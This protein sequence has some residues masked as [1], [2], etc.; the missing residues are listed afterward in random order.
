MEVGDRVKVIAKCSVQLSSSFKSEK[1]KIYEGEIKSLKDWMVGCP[2]VLLD[3][4]NLVDIGYYFDI[5]K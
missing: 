5:V 3:C 1:G 2:V 4:G